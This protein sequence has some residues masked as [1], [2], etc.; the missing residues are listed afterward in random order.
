MASIPTLGRLFSRPTLLLLLLL[1]YHRSSPCLAVDTSTNCRTVCRVRKYLLRTLV[2]MA[3]PLCVSCLRPETYFP[4]RCTAI[5]IYRRD[6]T[7][8]GVQHTHFKGFPRGRWRVLPQSNPSIPM[9][10]PQSRRETGRK[11]AAQPISGE[12]PPS[13]ADSARAPHHAAA[14]PFERSACEKSCGKS[15]PPFDWATS[16]GARASCRRG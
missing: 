14:P 16:R 7:S 12:L 15:Y 11:L 13:V 4:R 1:L 3:V 9:D 10:Q 5:R 6:V 2:P 8:T